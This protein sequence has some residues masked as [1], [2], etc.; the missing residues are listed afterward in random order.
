MAA[1]ADPRLARGLGEHPMSRVVPLVRAPTAGGQRISAHRVAASRFQGC[2]ETA[3]EP[4]TL[5]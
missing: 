1:G 4:A 5:S 2:M 3:G